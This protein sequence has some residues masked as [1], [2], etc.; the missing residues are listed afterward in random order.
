[1]WSP[2]QYSIRLSKHTQQNILFLIWAWLL[3]NLK[4]IH[5]KSLEYCSLFSIPVWSLYAPHVTNNW[6]LS[7]ETRW[8][9]PIWLAAC[10]SVLKAFSNSLSLVDGKL[11]FLWREYYN[12]LLW[13]H[14][15]LK[16]LCSFLI[17]VKATQSVFYA[18]RE[19]QCYWK[20]VVEVSCPADTLDFGHNSFR[21]T[22]RW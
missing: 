7:A 15:L 8:V 11:L 20:C 17:D 9:S 13:A 4:L 5:F 1:M 21:F 12:P 19:W 16:N 3:D 22:H 14:F 2:W 6:Y 10:L 18:I